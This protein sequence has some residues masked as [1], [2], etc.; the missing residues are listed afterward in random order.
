MPPQAATPEQTRLA[1]VNKQ[2]RPTAA[3]HTT[4]LQEYGGQRAPGPLH[5]FV[6]DRRPSALRLYL[7]LLCVALKDPWDYWLPNGAWARAIGLTSKAAEGTVSRSWSWLRHQR[8]VRTE[9]DRRILRVYALCEDG[10][11]GDRPRPTT[12]F[13]LPLTYVRSGWIETLDLPTTATLLIA[14]HRGRRGGWWD[15]RKEVAADWYGISADTLQRGLDRLQQH[16]LLE[17]RPRPV[18]DPRARFGTTTIIEYQLLGDFA[19][20]TY[21]GAH[22]GM[23]A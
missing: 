14:L 11:G 1:L 15:L 12:Y 20:G 7:L 17:A 19:T 21:V 6:R 16:S 9:R 5:W 18:T 22:D 8:L 23:G 3:I 10:S 2:H 13:R 4:F